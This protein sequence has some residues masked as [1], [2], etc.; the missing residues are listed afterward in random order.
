VSYFKNKISAVL[1]LLMAFIGPAAPAAQALDMHDQTMTVMCMEAMDH[2]QGAM[3]DLNSCD[4]QS[5]MTD[6]CDIECTCPMADFSFAIM[7]SSPQPG[8]KMAPLETSR[9]HLFGV[10][11]SIVSTLYRPPITL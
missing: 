9:V 5:A 8:W 2:S 3:N 11:E 4:S 6:C 10:R 1:L 7:L